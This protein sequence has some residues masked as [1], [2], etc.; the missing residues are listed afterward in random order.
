VVALTDD[1][2]DT[3]QVYEY[4]VYGRPGATDASHPNR[5]MFTGREYDKETGLYYYRARYYNPQIGRFLQT[6]PIGYGEGMNWY[7]YCGNNPS[8]YFDPSGTTYFTMTAIPD[9]QPGAGNG[10]MVTIYDDDNTVLRQSTQLDVSCGSKWLSDQ[11]DIF[12]DDWMHNQDAW[13][14][15]EGETSDQQ[16]TTFWILM[17]LKASGSLGD[18]DYG[19]LVANGWTIAWGSDD[20]IYDFQLGANPNT[21]TITWNQNIRWFYGSEGNSEE[22]PEAVDLLS[23]PPPLWFSMDDG[24]VKFLAHELQHAEDAVDNYRQDPRGRAARENRARTTENNVAKWLIG[25]HPSWYN[26]PDLYSYKDYMRP[27]WRQE[28]GNRPPGGG[29]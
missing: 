19:K 3:V 17:S 26:V 4:D 20:Y 27:M 7:R 14:L 28:Y 21:K 23:G 15:T 6:D 24:C 16:K 10:I 5:I 13:G 25:L 29:Q 2:S 9:G 8:N 22:D 1:E 18:I 12:T 11:T